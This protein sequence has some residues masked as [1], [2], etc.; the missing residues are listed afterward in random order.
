ME[1]SFVT[2]LR[3]TREERRGALRSED[4]VMPP[5]GKPSGSH[6]CQRVSAQFWSG[7]SRPWHLYLDHEDSVVQ[8]HFQV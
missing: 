4:H 3:P 6:L 7:P 1:T 5:P 8:G 2:C